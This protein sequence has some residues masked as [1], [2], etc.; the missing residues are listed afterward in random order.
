MD[1]L[2]S[3]HPISVPLEDPKDITQIFDAISYKKGDMIIRY[4]KNSLQPFQK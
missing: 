3:S 2:Q 1:S 4:L